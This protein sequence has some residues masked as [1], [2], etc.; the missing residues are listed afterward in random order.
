MHNTSLIEKPNT[1]IRA[2]QDAYTKQKFAICKLLAWDEQQYAE[3][4]YAT[5]LQYL[6]WYLPCDDDARNQLERSRLFWNWF[7]NQWAAHDYAYINSENIDKISLGLR[8]SCYEA[9]HCPRALAVEIKPNSVVL[10]SI[11]K[12]TYEFYTKG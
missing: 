1:Y 2:Y 5:G 10:E 11:K 3:Y 7:K 4:Q 9:L 12:K 8:Q 6:Y